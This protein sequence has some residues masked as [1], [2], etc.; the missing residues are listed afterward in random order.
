MKRIAAALFVLAC[1]LI[2]IQAGVQASTTPLPD[3]CSLQ[4]CG[5]QPTYNWTDGVLLTY[6]NPTH[7]VSHDFGSVGGTPC[8]LDGQ[9][10]TCATWWCNP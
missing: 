7:L 5:A 9:Q 6:C 10:V 1:L 2:M 3:P 4:L 8:M